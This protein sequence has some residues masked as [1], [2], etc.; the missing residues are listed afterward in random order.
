MNEKKAQ[1]EDGYTRIANELVDYLCF[2]TLSTNETKVLFAILRKTYGFHKKNDYIALSQ[3]ALLTRLQR[4]HISR[5]LKN[6]IVRQIVTVA[7]KFI[8]INTDV[9]SWKNH[10]PATVNSK[11]NVPYAVN[12]FTVAGISDLPPAALQ[13]KLIQK[14]LIQKKLY[15]KQNVQNFDQL[16]KQQY[17]SLCD[18]CADLGLMN[19]VEPNLFLKTLD[20][21]N[22]AF[23]VFAEIKECAYWCKEKKFRYFT[24]MRIRNW[25]KNK[26]KWNKEKLLRDQTARQDGVGKDVYKQKK[27]TVPVDI[28]LEDSRNL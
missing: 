1:L 12:G 10:L 9:A 25:L 28:T 14:K 23:P 5:S 2:C 18:L 7:G 8:G 13:K 22:S 4:S 16:S 21:Y 6:L 3:I 17:E 27:Y 24:V 20:E 11:K 26:K 19:G 15:D